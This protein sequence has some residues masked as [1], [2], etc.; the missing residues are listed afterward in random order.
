M[1]IFW[2]VDIGGT[3]SRFCCYESVEMRDLPEQAEE[4]GGEARQ[5]AKRLNLNLLREMQ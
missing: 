5:G 1:D 3:I 4:G 2:F